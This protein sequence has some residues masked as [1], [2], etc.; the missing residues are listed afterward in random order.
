MLYA[1]F[2]G[3]LLTTFKVM[4]KNFWLTSFMDSLSIRFNGH[5]PGE[6]GLGSVY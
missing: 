2:H 3:K 4:V 5:F 1:K 6:P